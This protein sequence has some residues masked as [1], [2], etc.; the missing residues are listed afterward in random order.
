MLP[1]LLCDRALSIQGYTIAMPINSGQTH[2]KAKTFA[3]RCAIHR[4][5]GMP[6]ISWLASRKA[7]ARACCHGQRRPSGAES[8][9]SRSAIVAGE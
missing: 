1:L 3:K 6:W 7:K 2:N 8:H 4:S 5:Q 9:A